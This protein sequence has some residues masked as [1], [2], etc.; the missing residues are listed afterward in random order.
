M[1]FKGNKITRIKRGNQVIPPQ[2]DRKLIYDKVYNTVRWQRLRRHYLNHYP[3]CEYCR[4][5]GKTV[6]ATVLDHIKPIRSGGE[7][8]NT[9]NMQGLCARCH[10]L[11]TN[12]DKQLHNRT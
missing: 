7:I 10:Q 2:P 5:Q 6:P 12:K 1:P 3:L 4:Q 11:K 8:W 9:D